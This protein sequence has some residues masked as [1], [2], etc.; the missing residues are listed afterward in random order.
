MKKV[1]CPICDRPMEARQPKDWPAYPFCGE[2]CKL[3]DLGRWLGESYRLE[4][5]RPS[6]EISPDEE[7]TEIP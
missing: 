4:S 1:R 5:L 2:R 7:M 6:E 3:I